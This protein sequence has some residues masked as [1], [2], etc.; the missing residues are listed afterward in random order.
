MSLK[1]LILIFNI[2][3]L[4]ASC[5]NTKNLRPN[6]NLFVGAD[7]KIKSTDKLSSSKRK[8]LE[9]QMHS[10]VRPKPNTT[11]LGV[12]F[13]LTVFNIFK[14]PKKPRGLI[15]W[16]KYK[17]GEPPVLASASALEKNRM[18][19]QNYLDN[20]GFFR[21]SV[22]MDTTIKNKKLHVTYTALLDTQYRI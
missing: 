18:V 11:I 12:R 15:Y 13:K 4:V 1:Q 17:V 5:S 9:S 16:L 22:Q 14:E 8:A 19:I 7:E 2:A 21:D 10:L 3:L 20:R 6:Q